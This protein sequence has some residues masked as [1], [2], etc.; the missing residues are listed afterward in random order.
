[1][2]YYKFLFV[3]GLASALLTSCAEDYKSDFIIEKPENIAQ[4]EY[5]NQYEPLR[6]Y[7]EKS[8]QSTFKIGSGISVSDFLKKTQVYSLVLSNFNEITAGNAMKHSSCVSKEGKMDFSQ[9][10]KLIIAAKEANLSIYGHTLCWHAQQNND[11]LNG[12]IAPVIITGEAG[13]GGYCMILQNETAKANAWDS[14]TFYELAAPLKK[15]Q[16]YTL[17][18]MAKATSAYTSSIFLQGGNQDYPGEFK[19]GTEWTELKITFKPN[20]DESNKIVFNFGTFAGKIYIDDIKLN[21]EGSTDYLINND[22]ENGTLE[23]WKSWGGTTETI[24][25]QGEGYG[26]STQIIEK[27]PAE[28][29]EILLTAL[30]TWIK[31]MMEASQG[32]VKAWDVVNEPMSDASPND[33]KSDPKREDKKNFYWQDYLSKDYARYAIKYARQHGGDDLKLFINDYNLEASYNDN[34]KCVGL[35]NMIKYWESDGVTKID[36]IG[37][38]MHVTLSLNL[39]TQ[40]KQEENIIKMYQLL[41]ATG[42]LIKISELD[43]GITDKAGNKIKTSQVTFE[44]EKLMA[45]FYKFI[46]E[47]YFEIIPAGQQYG[48]TMWSIKDSSDNASDTEW[49]AGEPIG[50]WYTNYNRKPAYAGFAEGLQK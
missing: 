16:S 43:M 26:S 37:T 22:F 3:A 39:D 21:P 25:K 49:R 32:Y 13:D 10:E 28:K 48:I 24:S 27:T 14:Q 6:T 18:C 19:I 17:S 30:E 1:M 5:L 20:Y 7:A 38:Q 29:K 40:K 2:K 34:A 46:V 35:I 42:K 4:Y 9:V 12:L 36:G 41:A 44:Q 50:L 23:G 45:D 33:L 8:A 31:G 47:K 11:Y 15:G